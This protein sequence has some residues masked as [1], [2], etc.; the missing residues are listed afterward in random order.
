MEAPSV[1]LLVGITSGAL[2]GALWRASARGVVSAEESRACAQLLG[3]LFTWILVSGAL[4]LN[5]TYLHPTALRFLPLLC[6]FLVPTLL[7]IVALW[8]SPRLR[9]GVVGVID[10]IPLRLLVGVQAIRISALG[11]IVKYL[12]GELPGHFIGP[13]AVPDLLVGLTALPMAVWLTRDPAHARRSLIVWN[14][15]GAAIFVGAG[16]LLHVSMPGPVQFFTSGPTTEAIFHFPMVLVPTFL[17][18]CFVGVH[19]ACLWRLRSV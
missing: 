11:T 9:S 6:G 2:V 10:S 17:V 18:P 16:I 13:V 4:A 15:F 12:E 8:L 19:A 1:P 3:V 14:V 5:G 7:V